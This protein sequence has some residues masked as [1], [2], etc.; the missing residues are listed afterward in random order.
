MITK[1]PCKSCGELIHP[2][3]ATKND[4]LCMPCKGGY[5]A[6]IEA[7]KK[8]RE[9]ERIYEQSAERKYWVAL[10]ERVHGS[11]EGFQLLADA[12]KTYYAV[13]CLIGE[14]YN[15]GFDQFFSNSSGALY[16]YALDGLLEMGAQESA[17]LLS[18]AKQIIVGEA[19][20]PL[21]G[22]ECNTEL[23][24]NESSSELEALDK[25]FWTDPDNLGE[26]CKQ[27]AI[28]H[29]LHAADEEFFRVDLGH[30][31]SHL[32]RAWHSRNLIGELRA[33]K[34]HEA[35]K[36]PTDLDPT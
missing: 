20:I 31:F 13:S 22:A 3:T 36:F 30:I 14:V 15:G 17:S 7:S 12:E 34:W 26:R 4:G 5:R 1:L 29:Q 25:A 35:S 16:V 6:N 11:P 19:H 23:R 10:V 33:N 24:E 9:E 32:N 27:Y 18:R 21:D 8:R 28:S 2:D